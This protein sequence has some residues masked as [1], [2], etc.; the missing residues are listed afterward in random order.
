MDNDMDD[1][2]SDPLYT[3]ES[4]R[5]PHTQHLGT[6]L[7]SPLPLLLGGCP[8]PDSSKTRMGYDGRLLPALRECPCKFT[9]YVDW[10]H[11]LKNLKQTSRAVRNHCA[12]ILDS[13]VQAG[14][15][16]ANQQEL[17]E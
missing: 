8:C 5:Q 2:S 13:K 7:H 9:F 17:P 15:A 12:K 3:S 6:T 4:R 1:A 14:T 10:L 11:K 16:Q